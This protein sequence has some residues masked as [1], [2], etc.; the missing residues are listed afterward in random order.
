L[1]D[2]GHFGVSEL[3]PKIFNR[4]KTNQGRAEEAYPFNTTYASN[5]ETGQNEPCEP[6]N[7]EAFVLKPMEPSP[8]EYS[9]ERKTEEHGIQKDESANGCVGV[10]AQDHKCNEPNSR[11]LEVQLARSIIRKRYANSPEESVEGTHEGIIEFIWI[12]LPRFELERPIIACKVAGETN[13]HL[14]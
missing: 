8:A 1:T 3:V 14:S 12:F 5:A 6:F 7:A 10:L 11:A 9:S 13:E 2:L 4:V